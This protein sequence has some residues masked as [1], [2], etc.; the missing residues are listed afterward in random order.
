[1]I[2]HLTHKPETTYRTFLCFLSN[3]PVERREHED[4]LNLILEA[5]A[6]GAAAL[7]QTAGAA[8]KDAYHGLK[9]L[10]Q[11]QLTDQPKAHTAL[12][13]YEEDPDTSEKPLTKALSTPHLDQ[14][15]EIIVT[16]RRLLTLLA[17]NKQAQEAL[18][19]S[20]WEPCRAR[21]YL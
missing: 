6:T 2:E 12:V 8:L 11:R 1:M 14:D 4:D 17:P 9:S 18:A 16:A 10:L 21:L 19:C 20:I 13:E 3:H 7:Q 15:E 5:L